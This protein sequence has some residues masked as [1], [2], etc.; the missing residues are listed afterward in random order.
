MCEVRGRTRNCQSFSNKSMIYVDITSLEINS[1]SFTIHEPFHE[2][3]PTIR[4]GNG[5]D[6]KP[7][8]GSC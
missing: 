3:E 6:S 7:A 8:L 5:S 1:L 4:A 2:A